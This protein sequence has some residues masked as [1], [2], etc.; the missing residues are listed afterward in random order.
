VKMQ[1]NI[2]FYNTLGWPTFPVNSDTK[3]PACTGWKDR[4]AD[5]LSAMGEMLEYTRAGA[6]GVVL[7]PDDLVIDLDKRNFKDNVNPWKKLRTDLGLGQVPGPA[8]ETGNGVHIY[9]KKP[10]NV[11]LRASVPGYEG[12]D[13][14]SGAPGKGTYVIGPGSKHPSGK[15][16]KFIKETP[17]LE[18]ILQIPAQILDL[19][20]SKPKTE[21]KLP[22]TF[23]GGEQ[24]FNRYAAFLEGTEVPAMV[25]RGGDAQRFRIACVGRDYGLKPKDTLRALQEHFN[26]HCVP[27]WDNDQLKTCIRNAYKYA[28]GPAGKE[29]PA[30]VF[31]PEKVEWDNEEDS[32]RAWDMDSHGE[33]PR[34]TL[35]N[36]INYL[37][38][39]PEL[40]DTVKYN[41]FTGDLE[42]TGELP[43]HEQ[44][45]PGKTWTDT[46]IILLKYHLSKS[47]K[48][49]FSIAILWEAV[50]A[51]GMRYAYHPIRKFISELK[52]DGEERL[53]TWL[54]RYCGTS[55]N[56]Y[57]QN[58]GRKLLL[59][60]IARVFRPGVKFDYCVVLEG[61]QGIGKST[62]C[63]ILGGDWYGDVIIDPRNKD[64]IDALRGKWVIE[65]SEMEVTRR[66]DAQALKAFVSRTSDRA[67]LAYARAA[68]DFPRQCVF[69][70]TINPDDMGYLVDATGN[71]RFWPVK[72]GAG[73]INMNGLAAV[74]DQ[75]L[76]EAYV[77][78]GKGE[79]LYL[80]GDILKFA[81]M[82]QNKRMAVDPWKDVIDAY[83]TEEGIGIQEISVP[84]VWEIVLGGQARNLGRMEQARIGR[85]MTQLRWWKSRPMRGGS[86]QYIH[87]RP[88]EVT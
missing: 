14:K 84:Q 36:A 82:E 39:R 69:I 60:M 81:E 50:H 11:Y 65:L 73:M 87:K 15:V 12:L 7:Q 33:S 55:D 75:L 22:D 77:A 80:T 68:L 44:R 21:E 46:D 64:T 70:G 35:K 85:I 43:W 29:D 48:L 1:D 9:F 78:Y 16:Y 28:T 88:V 2:I 31:T 66:A 63:A 45:G 37:Y 25:K 32:T 79:D 10:S 42:L 13:I 76:A 17:N 61:A 62:V 47:S 8:V 57:T 19:F 5:A 23:T 4:K 56:E 54:N 20:T 34:K 72:C 6:F 67:R 41:Q 51:A 83:F 26:P 27:V 38:T 74:R 71:R 86:R 24:E 58:V 53:N 30:R 3:A 49:E 59:G 40:A 52:W 18:K